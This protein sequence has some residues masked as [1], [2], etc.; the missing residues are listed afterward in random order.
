MGNSRHHKHSQSHGRAA[1]EK[2]ALRRVEEARSSYARAADRLASLRVRTLRAEEKLV[3]RTTRLGRAEEA[4]ATLAHVGNDAAAGSAAPSASGAPA[5]IAAAIVTGG[6]L[7][8][9]QAAEELAR[10]EAANGNG[11][12]PRRSRTRRPSS[13]TDEV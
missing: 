11:A 4:L 12:K 7:T 3:R 6:P 9:V 8:P 1:L 13:T 2:K 10:A 5:T